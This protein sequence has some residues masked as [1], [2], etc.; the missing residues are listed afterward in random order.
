MAIIASRFLRVK[1]TIHSIM[2][3]HPTLGDDAVTDF[4]TFLDDDLITLLEA[5]LDQPRLESPRGDFDENP[6]AVSLQNKR[7]RWDNRHGLCR[8]KESDV[9][10][11]GRL[12]PVFRIGKSNTD[13]RPA[14]VRIKNL[15]YEQRAALEDFSRI[16]N[17]TDVDALI[18]RDQRDV[19]FR[20]VGGDPHG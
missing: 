12:Q 19:L 6:I 11:H 20:H 5:R 2:E 17:K 15:A 3:K 13:L 14:R 18:F 4:E 16:G 7:S 10:E 1:P 8:C 9:G